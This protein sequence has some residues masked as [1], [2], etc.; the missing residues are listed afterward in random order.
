MTQITYKKNEFNDISKLKVRLSDLIDTDGH[1]TRNERTNRITR[2]LYSLM[3]R[4]QAEEPIKK[5]RSY[6]K[7]YDQYLRWKM[8][9]VVM[10]IDKDPSSR[11][12]LL[13]FDKLFKRTVPCFTT[14]QFRVFNK[15]LH[16]IIFQRS[17]EISFLEQDLSFYAYLLREI[18]IACNLTFDSYSLTIGS[19]HRNYDETWKT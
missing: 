15:Q 10:Q 7:S 2:E 14:I 8:H 5:Y 1:F 12:I 4:V 19:L 6:Y 13:N 9:R 16:A 18:A 3:L 17:M 11:Q